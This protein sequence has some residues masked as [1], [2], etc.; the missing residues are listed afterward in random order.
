VEQRWF[1]RDKT[2]KVQKEKVVAYQDPSN[3]HTIV[4]HCSATREGQDFSAK[5]IDKWHRAKGWNGI[6][7]HRVIKLDGTVELG[8]SISTRGAHVAGNN[9]NTLGIC[10]IG[11]LDAEGKPKNTFTGPQFKSLLLEINAL[12]DQCP[13]LNR[14]CGHRDFSPDLNGDG[15][16]TRNEWIKECPCVEVKDLLECWDLGELANGA[17]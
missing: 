6:G 9:L 17:Q 10:L 5:D 8:R 16:I 2:I 15:V 4:V 12:R 7:Y 1:C 13:S 14:V 11:G 3:I